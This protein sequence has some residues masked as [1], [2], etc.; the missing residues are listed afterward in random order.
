MRTVSAIVVLLGLTVLWLA[1]CG[2]P[3]AVAADEDPFAHLIGKPAPDLVGDF[4]IN[5][6]PG[7][8]SD[9]RG[10]VVLV[11]FWAVWCGPCVRMFPQLQEWRKTYGEDGFEILG[12]TSYYK[13]YAFDKALGKLKFA[14]KKVED[15]ETG[16]VTVTGGLDKEAEEAMLKDFVRHHKLKHRILVQSKEQWGKGGEEYKRRAIPQAVLID[17]GGVVRMVKV[18]SHP[19]NLAALEEA[20]QKLV[21]EK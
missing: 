10:K 16:K 4:A 6:Q 7:K 9:L 19:D 12:V 3:G 17:R 18:G 15:P 13:Y 11:D 8:L 21:K 5:G 2:T 20:I 14:G 1:P